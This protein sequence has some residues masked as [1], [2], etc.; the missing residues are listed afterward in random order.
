MELI[1]KQSDTCVYPSHWEV[2]EGS[3]KQ[4]IKVKNLE[5]Y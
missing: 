4:H 3:G 5:H 1:L 2:K